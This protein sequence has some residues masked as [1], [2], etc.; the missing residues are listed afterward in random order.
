[1]K[2]KC[3][4][5]RR[6][7]YTDQTLSKCRVCGE[8]LEDISTP[9]EEITC[10]AAGE[11]TKVINGIPGCVHFQLVNAMGHRCMRRENPGKCTVASLPRY[12]PRVGVEM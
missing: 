9:T 7:F 11:K 8:K 1:M 6:V 4:N 5:C 3:T 2:L 10:Q 12:N